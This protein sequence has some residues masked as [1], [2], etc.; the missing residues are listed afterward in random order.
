MA[1]AVTQPG[2]TRSLDCFYLDKYYLGVLHLP[3]QS[4]AHSKP[5]IYQIRKL[6]RKATSC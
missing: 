4:P 5:G 6:E 1:V 3:Q 2:R